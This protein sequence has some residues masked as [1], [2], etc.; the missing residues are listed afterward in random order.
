MAI[1][2]CNECGAKYSDKAPGCPNCSNLS[3]SNKVTCPLCHTG[4][5]KVARVPLF[6]DAIVRFFGWILATPAIIVLG[7]AFY[8]LVKGQIEAAFIML[9]TAATI[10]IIGF[11]LISTRPVLICQNCRHF[12][13]R[14]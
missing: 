5:M 6:Q 11:I 7:F 2:K 8:F 14:G 12:L 3:D 4:H 9:G 10:G 1:I 13:P